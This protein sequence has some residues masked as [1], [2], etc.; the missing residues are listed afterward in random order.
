[1]KSVQN[2]DLLFLATFSKDTDRIVATAVLSS[3]GDGDLYWL[4]FVNSESV[5]KVFV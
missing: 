2:G 1:M 5:S 4:W 3:H